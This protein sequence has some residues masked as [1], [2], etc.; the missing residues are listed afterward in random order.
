[1]TIRYIAPKCRSPTSDACFIIHTFACPMILSSSFR[2]SQ[3]RHLAGSLNSTLSQKV[4]QSKKM[5]QK[6]W[7]IF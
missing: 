2:C 7:C 5:R 1:M 3:S 4:R 6:K